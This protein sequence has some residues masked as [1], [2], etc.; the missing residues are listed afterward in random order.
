MRKDCEGCAYLR[1]FGYCIYNGECTDLDSWTDILDV[2]KMADIDDYKKLPEST[3]CCY[4]I[5]KYGKHSHS[6]ETEIV[7][8]DEPNRVVGT[9]GGIRNDAD[10]PDWSLLPLKTIEGLVKVLTYGAK[11]YSRDNWK[12]VSNERNFAALMRHLSKWQDGEE[13]DPESGLH[14]LDHALCDLMF[15]RHNIVPHI[16]KGDECKEC[17]Q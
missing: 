10:K 5:S 3:I 13:F 17:L 11:K 1:G 8:V 15:I 6:P 16:Y 2:T 9:R 4:E 7:Y 14:H 12:K